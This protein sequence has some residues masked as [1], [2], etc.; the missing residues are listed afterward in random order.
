MRMFFSFPSGGPVVRCVH[1]GTTVECAFSSP[2]SPPFF[3]FHPILSLVVVIS[4]KSQRIVGNEDS[5]VL[6]TYR[7]GLGFFLFVLS[8]SSYA[9]WANLPLVASRWLYEPAHP[10]PLVVLILQENFFSPVSV[11]RASRHRVPF[12]LTYPDFDVFGFCEQFH[13]FFPSAPLGGS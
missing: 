12:S 6:M 10:S 11:S 7:R 13:S 8:L 4:T 1:S 9:S 3:F 5:K 2:L